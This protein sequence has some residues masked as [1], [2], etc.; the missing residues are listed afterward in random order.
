MATVG[1][2]PVEEKR[3]AQILAGKRKLKIPSHSTARIYLIFGFLLF[4]CVLRS[5]W[6]KVG[7]CQHHEWINLILH[8]SVEN[9]HAHLRHLSRDSV[10]LRPTIM[11]GNKARIKCNNNFSLDLKHNTDV[12]IRT[13]F[14]MSQFIDFNKVVNKSLSS[15]SA[16]CIMCW[17]VEWATVK[18]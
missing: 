2:K 12:D 3:I 1:T 14:K 16:L 18:R 4:S 17:A 8:K 11:A 10:E 5:I 13:E 7:S 9:P 15:R 6:L